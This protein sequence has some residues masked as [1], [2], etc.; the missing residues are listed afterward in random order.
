[1]TVLFQDKGTYQTASAPINIAVVSVR[2]VA[3]ATA[4]DITTF[5]ETYKG[6]ILDVPRPGGFYRI[7]IAGPTVSQEELKKVTARMEKDRIVE[8]IA[9]P[10]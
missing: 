7:H 10:Q 3:Q 9:A 2:F 4:A 8:M 5:L 1:M 6:S